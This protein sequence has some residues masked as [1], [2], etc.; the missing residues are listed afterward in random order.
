[1]TRKP[2]AV[3]LALTL[4][5]C[6][7]GSSD[8]P[9]DSTTTGSAAAPTEVYVAQLSP[10]NET[11]SGSQTRGE[12]RLTVTG[13]SINIRVDVQG[14]PPDIAHW[15]HIHG[16]LDNRASECPTASADTNGD[17]IVDLIETEPAAGTTMI[18]FNDAVTALDI[19]NESY[20]SASAD[21]SYHYE[22]TVSLGALQSAVSSS[23]EGQ[24]LDPG[25]RVV[26][27]HGVPTSTTLPATVQSLGP[28]PAHTTLPIACGKLERQG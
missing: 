26:F 21:G 14:A 2:A 27:I 20:P 25:R 6:S 18:P 16:F 7:S 11:Q 5:A 10:L 3:L 9:V 28:I 1:M 15:Q 17:G 23:Y 12:V 13:D 8:R 4:G 19:P 24:A 22:K